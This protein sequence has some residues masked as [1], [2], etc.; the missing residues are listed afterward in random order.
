MLPDP[1]RKQHSNDWRVMLTSRLVLSRITAAAPSRSPCLH[2]RPF[3][4]HSPRGSHSD[5]SQMP[6]GRWTGNPGKRYKKPQTRTTLSFFLYLDLDAE[7]K[8]PT[9]AAGPRAPITF[10]TVLSLVNVLATDSLA[11]E[12]SGPQPEGNSPETSDPS[13][14]PGGY[15]DATLQVGHSVHFGSA[16]SLIGK[17]GPIARDAGSGEGKQTKTSGGERIHVFLIERQ[18]RGWAVTQDNTEQLSPPQ[19]SKAEP[20]QRRKPEELS[21][22]KP[23]RDRRGQMGP[24]KPK[25]TQLLEL[26]GLRSSSRFERQVEHC[27]PGSCGQSQVISD[28]LS[29]LPQ[30]ISQNNSNEWVHP[31]PLFPSHPLQTLILGERASEESLAMRPGQ[32]YELTVVYAK[33]LWKGPG[34]MAVTNATEVLEVLSRVPAEDSG[35]QSSEGISRLSIRI[36]A[37]QQLYGTGRANVTRPILQ[38]EK[39]RPVG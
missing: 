14:E 24:L 21:I 5:V 9:W 6:T 29:S 19:Q 13:H 22:V 18:S 11:G 28:A 23:G 25:V 38:M 34:K 31:F 1:D 17:P 15:G 35:T 26:R 16:R 2:A 27:P 37:L 8:L 32:P 30:L 4:T 10:S 12:Q 39:Q 7:D 33:V 20:K 36:L 3:P